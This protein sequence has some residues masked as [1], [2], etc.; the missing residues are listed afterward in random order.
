M[1]LTDYISIYFLAHRVLKDKQDKIM[2]WMEIIRLRTQ[3]DVEKSVI[4][5]LN[6]LTRNIKDTPGL[7]EAKVY[8]H[9]AV[10]G[11]VGFH[12]RWS[13]PMGT[14]SESEIGLMVAETLK[15]Y[16]ILDHTVWLV[17]GNNGQ[18]KYREQRG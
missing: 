10:S 12:I 18:N 17:Q 1:Y 14:T 2:E 11:D 9:V 13:K 4:E 15:K 8:C 6:G 16:G 7:S 5:W 3:P